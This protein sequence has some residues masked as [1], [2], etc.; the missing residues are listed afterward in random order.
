MR[1]RNKVT[2]SRNWRQKHREYVC[3]DEV[4]VPFPNR[5]FRWNSSDY[6]DPDS[7]D[8][9]ITFLNMVVYK[10]TEESAQ[11]RI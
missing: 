4:S 10:R 1:N 6:K 9:E 2:A 11:S 8:G 3:A 5:A 7:K